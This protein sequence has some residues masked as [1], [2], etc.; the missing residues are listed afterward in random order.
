MTTL[1]RHRLTAVRRQAGPDA[2][3]GALAR[4]PA[5]PTV[6]QDHPGGTLLA[7]PATGRALAPLGPAG[8]LAV[9]CSG[10]R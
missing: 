8:P 10:D 2:V 6:L 5:V 9:H 7:R 1:Q 4:R 3:I